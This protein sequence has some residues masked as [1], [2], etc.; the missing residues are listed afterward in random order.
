M[1]HTCQNLS[2]KFL[3]EGYVQSPNLSAEQIQFVTQRANKS[4]NYFKCQAISR[5][6]SLLYY[7][8]FVKCL[9]DLLIIK[10]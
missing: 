1:P 5:P 7:H 6:E 9:I 8:R 3:E 10:I 2:Y 4:A